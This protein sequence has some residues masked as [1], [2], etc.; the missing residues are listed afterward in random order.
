M[1]VRFGGID[2]PPVVDIPPATNTS[3]VVDRPLATD[4]S[5]TVDRWQATKRLIADYMT[6]SNKVCTLLFC[7]ISAMT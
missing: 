4:T 7:H 6:V 1:A 3:P 2:T 5:S